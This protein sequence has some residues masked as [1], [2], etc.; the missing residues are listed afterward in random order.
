LQ[1]IPALPQGPQLLQGRKK[2]NPT[3]KITPPKCKTLAERAENR[4]AA[5]VAPISA[6]TLFFFLKN[7]D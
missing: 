7:K 1:L 2:G 5:R 6:P 4:N 3:L